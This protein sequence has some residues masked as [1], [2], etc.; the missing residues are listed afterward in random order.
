MIGIGSFAM[1]EEIKKSGLVLYF[2]AIS[3]CAAMSFA[4]STMYNDLGKDWNK[5]TRDDKLHITSYETWGAPALGRAGRA[6]QK[7][8]NMLFYLS[9]SVVFLFLVRGQ[10]AVAVRA[11]TDWTADWSAATML[12]HVHDGK[13][14]SQ[15]GC[16]EKP[17]SEE[18]IEANQTISKCAGLFMNYVGVG[19]VNKSDK[20]WTKWTPDNADNADKESAQFEK[21]LATDSVLVN[22]QV[23]NGPNVFLKP[24]NIKVK[25]DE[26]M[27]KHFPWAMTAI[28]CGIV[29]LFY[30]EMDGGNDENQAWWR[31]FLKPGVIG[32]VGVFLSWTAIV[33]GMFAGKSP[34]WKEDVKWFADE[35]AV[36]HD[37]IYKVFIGV[38]ATA[39]GSWGVLGL[40]PQWTNQLRKKQDFGLAV[41]AGHAVALAVYALPALFV[42]FMPV[43]TLVTE[44]FEMRLGD[45]FHFKA[46]N[47]TL[48][49]G[50]LCNVV[51][52][53]AVLVIQP[54]AHVQ[55]FVFENLNFTATKPWQTKVFR[56]VF[57]M[58]ELVLAS[59]FS[60]GFGKIF[61][62]IA[63]LFLPFS[64]CL[65]P[66]LFEVMTRRTLVN[67]NSM[68][69]TDEFT[70]NGSLRWSRIARW[71]VVLVFSVLATLC[72]ISTVQGLLKEADPDQT[73][74]VMSFPMWQNGVGKTVV[75]S[76]A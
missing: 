17:N 14:F 62:I 54:L 23:K 50:I 76:A 67:Q 69:W 42:V 39:L 40:V 27:A 7:A 11:S 63:G 3:M 41:G 71:V 5:A 25:Q 46:L 52:T 6:M 22:L 56:A 4:A 16:K 1:P 55:K 38:F 49:V 66:L 15:V 43:E 24:S 57:V 44:M 68:K 37:G 28:L 45:G 73:M 32:T 36:K 74:S 12:K 29:T 51:C 2:I 19:S 53:Y 33:V 60:S 59:L 21:F 72:F 64:S 9:I 34:T 75:V 61:G 10:F 48:I 13:S 35:E 65:L 70:Q 26:G 20:S 8:I 47:V 18:F 58:L 30:E 31:Q